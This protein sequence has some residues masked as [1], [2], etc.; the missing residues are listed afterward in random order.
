MFYPRDLFLDLGP[1]C[2]KKLRKKLYLESVRKRSTKNAEFL[3]RYKKFCGCKK[4]GEK[5]IEFLTFHHINRKN[6]IAPYRLRKYHIKRVKKEVRKCIVLCRKC[7]DTSHN[8]RR[9]KRGKLIAPLFFNFRKF[10]YSHCSAKSTI[11]YYIY[12]YLFIN[13][14]I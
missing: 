9:K 4:C 8:I 13:I 14:P 11:I 6:K 3:R 5:E 1:K 12:S 2:D 7:H 10:L